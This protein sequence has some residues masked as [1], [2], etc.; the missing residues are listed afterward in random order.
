MDKNVI[1]I[2]LFFILLII[3]VP[4]VSA[5]EI[6]I[7]GTDIYGLSD[8]VVYTDTIDDADLLQ[9]TSDT[10]YFNASVQKDGDGSITNP[11]KYL[12]SD[13][14]NRISTAYFA[15]GVY[16]LD[17]YRGIY[18]DLEL[19]GQSAENT[20]IRYDGMAF[21]IGV[22][23]SL[24]ASNITF[25][26]SSIRD[27]G[28]FVAEDCIFRD[29]VAAYVDTYGNSFGGAIYCK[30]GG[31]S[32]IY[33]PGSFL[34]NCTFINNNAQYGGAVYVEIGVLSISNSRFINNTASAFGGAV[35]CEDGTTLMVYDS[36]F[37]RDISLDD[38]GGA[39]YGKTSS[40]IISN[41]D[42]L[43]CQAIFGG[44]ICNLN[45]QLDVSSSRFKNNTA[46]YDGGATYSMYGR[47]SILNSDFESNLALN[48]GAIFI[49]NCTSAS[50]NS[51]TFTSNVAATGAVL[52]SNANPRLT[53]NSNVFSNNTAL[54]DDEFHIQDNYPVVVE[55][56]GNYH[57]IGN[58]SDWEGEIPS[59]YNLFD[60]GLST[61]VRDQQNG[62][63]CWGFSAIGALES[64][65]L[66]ASNMSLDFSEENIKNV[67]ELY[68]AFGWKRDTNEGGYD[69][70]AFAYLVSWLGPIF[71][72]Y[73]AYDDYSTLSPVLDSVVHVQDLIFAPMRHNYTDNDGI[74]KTI[75]KYGA[76]SAAYGHSSDYYNPVTCAYYYPNDGYGN[77]AITVI[78]WDDSFSASNFLITPP[79]D[80]A[81]IIKNSW[82]DTWGDKGCFYISYYD[83][84]LFDL[85]NPESAYTFF[86]TNP[87]NFTKNYQYDYAGLTDYLITGRP[88]MWY[89][90]QFNSTGRDYISA[91][92][93]YFEDDT[94]FTAYVYVNDELKL[95]QTGSSIPGYHTI[96]FN[97]SVPVNVGD[98]FRVSLKITTSHYANVPISESVMSTRTYY[99]PGV[100]YISFNGRTWLD[101]YN[102]TFGYGTHS[103]S[104]QVACLKV[105]TTAREDSNTTITLNDTS[106]HVGSQ[107]TIKAQVSDDEGNLL[108]CGNVTFSINN[109]S[110]VRDVVEGFANL[111][112]TFDSEGIYN[113]SAV[114]S[115]LNYYLPSNATATVNISK[116]L[117]EISLNVTN[118]TFKERLVAYISLND[119]ISSNVTLKII[120]MTYDITERG[121]FIIDDI[122]DAGQYLAVLTFYGNGKYMNST[123]SS[124]F[125][126]SPRDVDMN[127]SVI[128]STDGVNITVR[129]SEPV[130]DN[131]TLIVGNETYQIKIINST[132]ECRL[133]DLE[134]GT[135]DVNVSFTSKNYEDKSLNT[136]FEFEKKYK[137]F[138]E[139][140]DLEKYYKSD[141]K[142]NI[143]LTDSN[144]DVLV[145]ETVVFEISGV[146]YT[147]YTDENGIAS[148]AINLSPGTYNITTYYNGSISKTNAVSVLSTIEG[149]DLVKYFRNATQYEATV[150]DSQGELLTNQNFTFNINGVFY[151]RT[152]N[153]NGVV[154]L[155]INLSPGEYIITVLNNVTGQKSSNNIT[156]L[157][158]LVENN[159][160]TKYY[161]NASQYSV[162]VL[163]DVG[164]PL[165][166]V[167]V[168]F[169]INGVF[170]QKTTNSDGIATL[171][172]NLSPGDYIITAEYEN[173]RVSN[174]IK[175]LPTL[176]GENLNMHYRDGS[177]FNATVLDDIGNPLGGV[178]VTFNI[179]GVFYDRQ[180]DANGVSRLNINL[181]SGEYIITSS[182]NNLNIANRIT[183][184]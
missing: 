117:P 104:S 5:D 148:L 180:S 6:D 55:G 134:S 119:D 35:S 17:S 152:S 166:G 57:F 64:C 8:D 144:D 160:L 113:I 103:Y 98:T 72:E 29:C 165:A 13:R 145:N 161:R 106:G 23:A 31:I 65:I 32:S 56:N 116:A 80:G 111:T 115:S 100:S 167:N 164:N 112:L 2:L 159:D 81:W 61:P 25:L 172:I 170:Y 184:I 137:V 26:K 142:F 82:N 33:S 143:T 120:N 69:E 21:S 162:K 40:M 175:V 182:Y 155:N 101:L 45:G 133:N 179:N 174:N 7:N 128:N 43:N 19:I 77:H 54:I 110:Y 12:R 10:V 151:T 141:K 30:S 102:Y 83:A 87:I 157:S 3:V 67:I 79:G 68:S 49:D 71:D 107:V 52:Y 18:T 16:R 76:I 177:T 14:L 86:F 138:I 92:A 88:S 154:R 135:Y 53:Y 124:S 108:N 1:G 139:S 97:E 168:T 181:M 90:N 136:S 36:Y 73:D 171:N 41:S 121:E 78:G 153:E 38:A 169:N 147:R 66:K 109:Q 20:I 89:A 158:K 70:M 74:K 183:I 46:S 24:Y 22:D 27:F 93:T 15:D 4:G 123:V 126:V 47:T 150:Y 85:G 122:V 94:D 163:D 91:F 146:N 9:A 48:G 51:N 75:L 39:I 156:V 132:A 140:Q 84:I 11:Y 131:V 130:D 63:N 118:I 127:V 58:Y 125:A 44:A 149:K 37:D 59:Y 95:T 176:I 96:N 50:I 105:F 114:Y 28:V 34:T 173:Q 178:N 60:E 129:F 42:F 99:K 62:G